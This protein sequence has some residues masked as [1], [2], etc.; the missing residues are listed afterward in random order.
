MWKQNPNDPFQV[1]TLVRTINSGRRARVIEYRGKLGPAGASV[2]GIMLRR[3][4]F[5]YT[6][7]LADQ[8][9][10]WRLDQPTPGGDNADAAR[11]DDIIG[12]T[13]KEDLAKSP[14]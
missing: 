12:P 8:I 5:S 10:P 14:E 9:E 7:V 11:S 2:Y 13:I 3:K 1:G 6:E 4:P